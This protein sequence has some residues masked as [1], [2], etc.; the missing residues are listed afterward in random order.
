VLRASN[1]HPPAKRWWLRPV[2]FRRDRRR[3]G[4]GSAAD[5]DIA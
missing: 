5:S 4:G 3:P 1:A 2:S